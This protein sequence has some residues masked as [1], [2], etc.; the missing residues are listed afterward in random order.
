[1]TLTITHGLERARRRRGC[2]AAPDYFSAPSDEAAARA[3]GID[4]DLHEPPY[5][6]RPRGAW[7]M[8]ATS[9]GGQR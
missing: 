5:D 1:M 6:V 7:A 8:K 2:G 4:V 9:V 3:I